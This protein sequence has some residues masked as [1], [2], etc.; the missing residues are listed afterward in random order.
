MADHD[1]KVIQAGMTLFA[2]KIHLDFQLFFS[3]M[4]EDTHTFQV[5]GG[6]KS[7]V[8]FGDRLCSVL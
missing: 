3:L 6:A 5:K 2:G 4:W 8:R 7:V 1:V